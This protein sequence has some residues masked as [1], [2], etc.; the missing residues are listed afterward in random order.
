VAESASQI[1]LRELLHLVVG[2]E[3]RKGGNTTTAG[4]YYREVKARTAFLG[5]SRKS[6]KS[7]YSKPLPLHL[8]L[9]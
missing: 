2:E 1:F 7:Y 3:D 8:Y 6:G 9:Q 4:N 5:I